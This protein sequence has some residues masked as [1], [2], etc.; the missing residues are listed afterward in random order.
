MGQIVDARRCSG[1]VELLTFRGL[2]VIVAPSHRY[3]LQFR[4]AFE[5][6]TTA[7]LLDEQRLVVVD[8]AKGDLRAGR[9]QRPIQRSG[10]YLEQS[11]V[12][13]MPMVVLRMEES[14]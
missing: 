12:A 6:S 1:D 9:P 8:Q 11:H 13:L 7:A 14:D 3:A 10:A 2:V 5:V 4:V